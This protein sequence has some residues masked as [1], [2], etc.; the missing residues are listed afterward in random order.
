MYYPHFPPKWFK[1]FEG[2]LIF[3]LFLMMF[4][5]A[6]FLFGFLGNKILFIAWD[7]SRRV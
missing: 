5:I 1:I 4:K 7:K 2:T 6:N 3:N